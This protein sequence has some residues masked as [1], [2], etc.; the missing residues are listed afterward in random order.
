MS[1]YSVEGKARERLSVSASL[2]V[3]RWLSETGRSEAG[4]SEAMGAVELFGF[5]GDRLT[6]NQHPT[7][8]TVG[9]EEGVC[10]RCCACIALISFSSSI[11]GERAR[12]RD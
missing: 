8:Q 9:E 10:A 6:D 4:R 2:H 7:R 3:S 12:K 5:L 1:D 11:L